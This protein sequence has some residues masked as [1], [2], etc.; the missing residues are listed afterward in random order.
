[1]L[2]C[3]C[4]KNAVP[5]PRI[6]YNSW[7]FSVFLTFYLPLSGFFKRKFWSV[8]LIDCFPWMPGDYSP[9]VHIYMWGTFIFILQVKHYLYTSFLFMNF[10]FHF[11]IFFIGAYPKFSLLWAFPLGLVQFHL[12]R[13]FLIPSRDPETIVADGKLAEGFTVPYRFR[14]TFFAFNLCFFPAH[15]CLAFRF[16]ASVSTVSGTEW[17][18]G[19]PPIFPNIELEN[20]LTTLQTSR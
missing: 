11:F 14:L 20:G 19:W 16:W 5:Y 12:R 2:L 18:K 1:M 7:K 9:F 8:I 17:W 3:S 10:R 13:I 15:Q 6:F 4:F